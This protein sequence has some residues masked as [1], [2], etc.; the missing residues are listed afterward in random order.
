MVTSGT[1]GRTKAPSSNPRPTTLI[2]HPKNVPIRSPS[3]GTE[4]RHEHCLPDHRGA[5]LATSCA[6]GAEQP[7][8]VRALVDREHEA[9]GDVDEGDDGSEGE[10]CVHEVHDLV[11][12]CSAGVDVLA[13]ALHLRV[14]VGAGN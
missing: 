6:D 10:Q 4:E 14:R 8:F 2:D 5:G 11:E 7:E 9:V 12:L 13:P 3:N 1:I